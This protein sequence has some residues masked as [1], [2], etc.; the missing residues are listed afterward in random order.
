MIPI[1]LFIT[2]NEN[3][4]LIAGKHE[5]WIVDGIA[6]FECSYTVHTYLYTDTREWNYS[7]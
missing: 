4:N 5:R 1:S 6:G 3:A 2:H 7:V